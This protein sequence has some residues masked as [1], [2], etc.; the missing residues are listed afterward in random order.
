MDRDSLTQDYEAHYLF[1]F[2]P[3]P[4]EQGMEQRRAKLRRWTNVALSQS[5]LAVYLYRWR[6]RMIASGGRVAPDVLDLVSRALFRVQIGRRVRIGPGLMM[7]H[8]NVVIDGETVIGRDCQINPWV[9]I[10]LS[11]SKKVGF[12][13]RGPQIGDHVRIGTGAKILGPVTVGDYARIGANAVVVS[14][15]PANAT[16]VGMP[17]RVLSGDVTVAAEAHAAPLVNHDEQL[18]MRMR[19]A[20]VEYKLQRCS[21]ASLVQALEAVI[22]TDTPALRVLQADTADAFATLRSAGAD[23]ASPAV[24]DALEEIDAALRVLLQASAG[25]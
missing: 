24:G 7:P 11:N 25:H 1:T 9:T 18:G 17:A 16:V 23:G 21:L 5:W 15:V 4:D 20:I 12:S 6:A 19:A 2:A 10:G 3:I 22:E 8:G 14:D 13:V